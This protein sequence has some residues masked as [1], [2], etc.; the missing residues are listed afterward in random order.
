MI[1][2]VVFD[3]FET[4]VTLCGKG[5]YL[6]EDMAKDAGVPTRQF[7]ED[8]WQTEY[9]RSTGK[10]TTKEGIAITLKHCNVYS[11]ELLEKINTKRVESKRDVFD[12][13]QMHPGILPMLKAL[14]DKGLKIALISNCYSEEAR[15]IRSSEI[16][17]YIDVP[18]LSYEQHVCK[19]EPEIFEKC[20][21]ELGLSP[22][23]CL[24]VGDGGSNE[25]S[26]AKEVGMQ[27]V[28]AA[29]YLLDD[30][31]QPCGRLQDF[32]QADDP[33]DIVKRV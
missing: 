20:L 13:D 33:M 7:Q 16:F 17:P 32:E 5:R 23:E 24:Y 18:I 31:R 25:L 28:Q 11:E 1:K 3:V 15:A 26:A 21:Q 27:P 29:W 10:L 2:A 8:W 9:D 30:K 12:A 14:K 6:S 22:Q 4:L 19:P